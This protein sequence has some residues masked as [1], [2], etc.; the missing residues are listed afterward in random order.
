VRADLQTPVTSRENRPLRQNAGFGIAYGALL[1]LGHTLIHPVIV[2]ALYVSLISDSYLLV[3]LVPAL[4]TGVAVLPLLFGAGS[5]PGRAGGRATGVW[6]GI[7]RAAAIGLLG[8]AGFALGDG[9][10]QALPSP[11]SSPTRFTT[12]HPGSPTRRWSTSRH[13]S[14]RPTV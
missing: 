2:L 12:W 10:P 5:R 8:A 9:K 14:Y 11:S 3:G 13:I 7:I 4:A 6:A 1:V